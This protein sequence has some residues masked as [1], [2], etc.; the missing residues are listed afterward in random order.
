MHGNHENNR[1]HHTDDKIC[2]KKLIGERHNYYFANTILAPSVPSATAEPNA[3]M[4]NEI[5]PAP[6]G[7]KKPIT[8]D[9][10]SIFDISVR[11]L[12]RMSI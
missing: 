12:E 10:T 7:T 2:D 4:G 1:H 3:N 11:Y 9:A 5:G 6:V 8:T